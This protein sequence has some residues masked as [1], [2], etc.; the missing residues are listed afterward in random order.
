MLQSTYK[1]TCTTQLPS[2]STPTPSMQQHNQTLFVFTDSLWKLPT[3]VLALPWPLG[4]LIGRCQGW[5][6]AMSLSHWVE[7]TSPLRS[8]V[9]RATS[10]SGIW[11]CLTKPGVPWLVH[12]SVFHHCVLKRE[13]L[14]SNRAAS[15]LSAGMKTHKL[16]C[17]FSQR[18]WTW[19]G[20]RTWMQFSQ[21]TRNL[22]QTSL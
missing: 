17:S 15:K 6:L 20:E 18:L 19:L 8:V 2:F 12:L 16:K 11:I 5:F 10:T 1:P 14:C 13:A 21:Q 22:G 3:K 7:H 9:Y 4:V